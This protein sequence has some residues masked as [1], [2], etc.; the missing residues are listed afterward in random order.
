[1]NERMKELVKTVTRFDQDMDGSM[2]PSERGDWVQFDDLEKFAELIIQESITR[3]TR[4]GI[5]N[6][7]EDQSIM[8]CDELKEHFGVNE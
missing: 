2:E 5:L 8:A 7:C 3:I 4:M 1:M 6:N